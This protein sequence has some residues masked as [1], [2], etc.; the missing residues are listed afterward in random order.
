MKDEAYSSGDPARR[1]RWARE[2]FRF[3][4][5]NQSGSSISDPVWVAWVDEAVR[6]VIASSNAMP[7]VPEALFLK[8][9]LGMSG[10]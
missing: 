10:T 4:E 6:V 5:R 2:V 8:A 7:P 3:L 9:D 1:V